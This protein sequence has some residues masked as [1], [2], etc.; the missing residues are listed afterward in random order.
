MHKHWIPP[1]RPRRLQLLAGLGAAEPDRYAGRAMDD[2]F[3]VL[4]AWRAGDRSAGDALLRRHFDAL[5]R[6]FRNKVDQGVDDLIQRTFTACIAAKDNFR[7]QSSFRT[8]LFTVA[9]NELYHHYQRRQ[10]DAVMFEPGSMSVEAM[11]TSPSAV[12]ARQQE[13]RLLLRALRSLPLELQ[14]AIELFY[15]EQLSTQEIAEI[16]DVPQGTAKSRLRRAREELEDKIRE[17]AENPAVVESTLVAFDRWAA[18]IREL[19]GQP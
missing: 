3:A 17:L 9:R 14:V 7:K 16:M 2:D 18:S 1:A 10:R 15:W 4:D 12:L 5:Y 13:Q 8:Y 6:F 19:L 11:G